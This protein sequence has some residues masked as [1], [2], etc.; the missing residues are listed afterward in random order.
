MLDNTSMAE[1]LNNLNTVMSQLCLV[2]I[3]FDDKVR[4]FLL[5]LSLPDR[6]VGLVTAMSNFSGSSKL[7]FEDIVGVIVE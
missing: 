4:A 1:H 6:W 5:L 7:N 2:D 3:K